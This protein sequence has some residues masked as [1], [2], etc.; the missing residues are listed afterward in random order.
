MK[1]PHGAG[2]PCE[3][4]HLCCF[5]GV[6]RL[7]TL[8]LAWIFIW[9][10]FWHL[11]PLNRRLCP[12]FSYYFGGQGNIWPT[13]CCGDP[14][15]SLP[16]CPGPHA[17]TS[18]WICVC[19]CVPFYLAVMVATRLFIGSRKEH[20][21]SKRLPATW[22]LGVLGEGARSARVV[23]FPQTSEVRF[24]KGGS[25]TCQ[26]QQTQETLGGSQPCPFSLSLLTLNLQRACCLGGL[27]LRPIF[28]LLD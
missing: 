17:V 5:L 25:T 24:Q 22:G 26:V 4:G 16:L 12:G 28:S 14:L 7:L 3:G 11:S 9:T 6:P 23:L 15:I 18:W 20:P 8:D 10:S 13:T 27:V 2:W 1:L 19:V 21:Q